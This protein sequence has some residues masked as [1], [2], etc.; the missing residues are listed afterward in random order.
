VLEEAFVLIE[1]S[2]F[3]VFLELDLL[4]VTF[5]A[6]PDQYLINFDTFVQFKDKFQSLEGRLL[7]IFL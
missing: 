6:F 5:K 4:G 1:D 7:L 2:I 3:V